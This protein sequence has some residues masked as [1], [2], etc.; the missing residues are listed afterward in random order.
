MSLF[1]KGYPLDKF[2][3][4]L[5]SPVVIIYRILS[6][7][8]VIFFKLLRIHPNWVTFISFVTLFLSSYF[9]IIGSFAFAGIFIIIT[10]VLDC[11]DGI[12][13]RINNQQSNLGLK[14]ES[15]H[16]DLTLI[17]FPS[18]LIL[19][20]IKNSSVDVNVLFFLVISTSIYLKW[21]PFYSASNGMLSWADG[22][23]GGRSFTID[24]INDTENEPNEL[25]TI[26][27]YDPKNGLVLGDLKSS[28][29]KIYGS[30]SGTFRFA[31]GGYITS[32][33][34]ETVEILVTRGLGAKGAVQVDYEV[35]GGEDL[36]DIEIGSVQF[37]RRLPD[38]IVENAQRHAFIDP[39][40]NYKLKFKISLINE[41]VEDDKGI[42]EEIPH[43]KIEV[44]NN[45]KTFPDNFTVDD[46]IR[47]NFS[48]SNTG[49]TG[50]GGYILNEIIKY[51][52]KGRSL[53]WLDTDNPNSEYKTTYFFLIPLNL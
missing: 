51:H 24:I 15:I 7:P 19:G 35:K 20:L 49:N 33:F 36:S 38:T 3:T 47:R 13:A 46:L 2:K 16:A 41:I 5:N 42:E 45:G 6:I 27:L 21:R 10:F 30:E 23:K 26:N 4:E 9:S 22:E 32:E 1:T 12:L 53:L 34:D 18:A 28:T 31:S 52:N 44:A 25:F 29:V 39:K 14:L 37:A 48:A 17:I 11:V 43:V 50:Q 8:L 40:K